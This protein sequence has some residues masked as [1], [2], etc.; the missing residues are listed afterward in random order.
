M[1]N[2]VK[3]NLFDN[4]FTINTEE[5]EEY[6]KNLA[7]EINQRFK[8]LTDENGFLSPTMVASIAALQ[9]CDEDK[10]RRLECEELRVKSKTAL[11]LEAAARLEL[12]E[13]KSEIK[14][15][16]RENREIRIKMEQK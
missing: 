13:A 5:N 12:T 16:S 4:E 1:A 7:I 15:L 8:K 11:E 6:I 9:Y 3:I 10:K 14:R 2:K